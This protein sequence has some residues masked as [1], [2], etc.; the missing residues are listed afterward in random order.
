MLKKVISYLIIFSILFVDGA[1]CMDDD[2]GPRSRTG[3]VSSKGERRQSPRFSDDSQVH[4]QPRPPRV[5]EED[6]L[7]PQAGNTE[8]QDPQPPVP[9]DVSL[10]PDQGEALL[11]PPRHHHAPAPPSLSS[12]EDE[13]DE[14]YEDVF[15]DAEELLLGSVR[16]L[17]ELGRAEGILIGDF[18]HQETPSQKYLRLL[19]IN[20]QDFSF[21]ES[22]ALDHILRIEDSKLNHFV[23]ANLEVLFHKCFFA[24]TTNKHA[25]NKSKKREICNPLWLYGGPVPLDSHAAI[26][27]NIICK[28]FGNSLE[29]GIIESIHATLIA[30][31]GYQ[32]YEAVQSGKW[33]LNWSFITHFYRN[34]DGVSYLGII[35]NFHTYPALFTVLGIPVVYAVAQTLYNYLQVSEPVDEAISEDIKTL[36]N[37]SRAW[38][39][40]VFNLLS[41][42]PTLS[43]LLNFH[44][45]KRKMMG[46]TSLVLWDGKLSP[47]TRNNAFTA[48]FELASQRTGLSQMAALE[49]LARLA[50]GM[51]I[52][53]LRQGPHDVEN[54][55]HI[56]LSAFHYLQ[57]IYSTLPP[58]SLN[59]L[60][61]AVLL[62]E[63]GQNSSW[64]V[65]LCEPV[66]KAIRAVIYGYTFYGLFHVLYEFFTCPYEY[67]SSFSW[68]GGLEPYASD[69]SVACFD[70]QV[71]V[72][73]LLPGQPASTLVGDL[74]RYRFRGP[75][76]LDLSNKG[77][78][79]PVIAEIV[80]EF[81]KANVPLRSLEISNNTITDSS[82]IA[83]ILEALPSDILHLDL[84]N[85]SPNGLIFDSSHDFLGVGQLTGLQ[86]FNIS[87]NGLQ[88][89]DVGVIGEA[90]HNLS[91]LKELRLE[92]NG[93]FGD[94]TNITQ[95]A[96]SLK[97]SLTLL[98]LTNF[99]LEG[100]Y[101]GQ[102]ALGKALAQVPTLTQL[103]L[104]NTGIGVNDHTNTTV[105]LAHGLAAQQNLRILDLSANQLG[106]LYGRHGNVS[107]LLSS[108]P[109]SLT[110]L[111]VSDNEI[112]LQDSSQV[113]A[114]AQTVQ[115]MSELISFKG[116]TNAFCNPLDI[117]KA[118][119]K[120]QK[121]RVLDLS[122]N[123]C[124]EILPIRDLLQTTPN[125]KALDLSYNQLT[126]GSIL[127][128]PLSAFRNLK[129][130]QLGGNNFTTADRV[131]IW[132][133]TS[134]LLP[135]SPFPLD[136]DLNYT[137]AY[138]KSLDPTIPSLDLSGLIPNNLT[139]FETIMPQVVNLFPNLRALDLSNNN[140]LGVEEA[141][142]TY[143]I[144]GI[145]ALNTYL[146]R[147]THLQ[148]L[149]MSNAATSSINAPIP[150]ELKTF[151]QIIGQLPNLHTLDLSGTQFLIAN[152]LGKGLENSHS[153]TSINLANCW[154]HFTAPKNSWQG[155]IQLIQGLQG[156]THL[157]NLNLSGN[158]IGIDSSQ[159]SDP[160]STLALAK[161]LPFWS[162][163]QSLNLANNLIGY[164]DTSSA[165]I[166]LEKLADLAV[167]VNKQG[168]TL[169]VDLVDG[170]ISS[171]KWTQEA[172]VLATLM[173]KKIKDA[174]AAQICTGEPIS[175]PTKSK[176]HE[177]D[178]ER[179]WGSDPDTSPGSRSAPFY[180]GWIGS[181]K[182]WFSIEAWRS[183]CDRA[184]DSV[185]HVI[186]S[187]SKSVVEECPSY[188]PG[189]L[190]LSQPAFAGG[191]KAF[192][193]YPTPHI[194]ALAQAPFRDEEGFNHTQA[195]ENIFFSLSS[196]LLTGAPPLML[197]K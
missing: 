107:F 187:Y 131:S 51:N 72:F 77:I 78:F 167:T 141:N 176:T 192:Y 126:N 136:E 62:W 153:L 89:G 17:H 39:W 57:E 148:S 54:L 183:S 35:R 182:P 140:I 52:R 34:A 82:D 4:Y 108:L 134:S 1:A 97:P 65:R 41:T 194:R 2:S 102:I 168:R 122:Y 45:L 79:G 106:N 55:L 110:Y 154:N 146:P 69:Y 138:L 74:H 64:L 29:E 28:T 61:T 27:R 58:F 157:T 127:V 87:N 113:K 5:G 179:E 129:S 7:R 160:N 53:N 166:F 149:R 92:G 152:S 31:L 109:P 178:V 116:G 186:V 169:E 147:L 119:Q 21:G 159:K 170:I 32:I 165:S 98:D 47:E 177:T 8:A 43:S 23:W 195:S 73:N 12:S 164:V 67:L 38:D 123:G 185:V 145:Q 81:A 173:E 18:L 71:K 63:I 190:D 68:V 99:N 6:H 125:L 191:N 105:A 121:L 94:N 133:A 22:K 137:S 104:G 96:H 144:S 59:K 37:R 33:A 44:P 155:G 142:D 42:V 112:G 86:S 162:Q 189:K 25:I 117:L 14:G 172:Q 175:K 50:H 15:F 118:L 70:A 80:E 91:H 93:N 196:P 40:M 103:Y 56:K 120:K 174:C 139:A 95:I 161:A 124:T 83:R 26:K 101:E 13:E 143:I 46:L 132:K 197:S 114:L 20:L 130:L 84:S 9:A 30:L 193:N 181:L 11:P 3:K 85:N 188:F 75:Y 171:V 115:Q 16:S 48:L 184:L 24:L 36:K 163:L 128:P 158:P 111:D 66:I 150:V 90:L 10:L 156:Y 19:G 76:D 135:Q 49:S 60:T 151:S 180:Q 88:S 100:D